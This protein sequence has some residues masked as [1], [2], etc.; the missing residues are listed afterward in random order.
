MFF[1]F[2]SSLFDTVLSQASFKSSVDQNITFANVD[3]LKRPASTAR[4]PLVHVSNEY[5]PGNAGGCELSLN[6]SERNR[7]SLP[8]WVRVLAVKCGN[9]WQ[10]MQIRNLARLRC[11]CG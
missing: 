6:I 1:S 7:N 4:W 10:F 9:M 2:D 3:T 8:I 11:G 5:S